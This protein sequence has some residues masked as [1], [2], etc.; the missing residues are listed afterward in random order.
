MLCAGLIEIHRHAEDADTNVR[1][2]ALLA[3]TEVF[4]PSLLLHTATL[5]CFVVLYGI[6]CCCLVLSCPIASGCMA[7]QWVIL[8]LRAC[9]SALAI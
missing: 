9:L 1:C 2:L 3:Q 8:T 5:W 4:F 7:Y 6:S